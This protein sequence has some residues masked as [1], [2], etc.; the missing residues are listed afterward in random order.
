LRNWITIKGL[1]VKTGDK[2]NI[3]DYNDRGKLSE[4]I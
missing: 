2:M 1:E 3:L 4:D